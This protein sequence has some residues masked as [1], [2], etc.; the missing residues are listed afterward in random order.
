MEKSIAQQLQQ[1][2]QAYAPDARMAF[3]G[4][5][6]VEKQGAN[7]STKSDYDIVMLV[8]HVAYPVSYNNIPGPE[9]RHVDLII[10]DP[11][12]L[13]F[14]VEEA[15]RHA[16][17]AVLSIIAEGQLIFGDQKKAKPL[18]MEIGNA[19]LAGPDKINAV[20]YLYRFMELQNLDWCSKLSNGPERQLAI[21]ELTHEAADLYLRAKRCWTANGKVLDR[22]LQPHQEFKHKLD[23]ASEKGDPWSL[24]YEV[25]RKASSDGRLKDGKYDDVTLRYAEE[26]EDKEIQDKFMLRYSDDYLAGNLRHGT[27]IQKAHAYEFL[28]YKIPAVAAAMDKERLVRAPGEYNM[29][30]SRLVYTMAKTAHALSPTPNVH[31]YKA[32]CD[33]LPEFYAQVTEAQQG[34]PEILQQAV[35]GFVRLKFGEGDTD[36]FK[37]C[38][39]R[40]FRSAASFEF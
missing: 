40:T 13:S 33:M 26:E 29:A 37:R 31:R 16:R 21:Y 23:E 20:H 11:E 25:T 10:R 18:Q 14:E 5:S 19:I 3:L 9:G 17:K 15:K 27:V 30:L 32:L 6:M 2:C 8:P 1:I 4:G 24:M 34:K 35:K 28:R 7:K 36:I 39:P 12:T 22:L 38:S